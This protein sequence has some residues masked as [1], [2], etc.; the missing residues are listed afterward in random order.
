MQS[1]T[2]TP[3]PFCYRQA[4][5]YPEDFSVCDQGKPASSLSHSI[6]QDQ[7]L[8]L[9]NEIAT[10]AT[11]DIGNG[12]NYDDKKL[13]QPGGGLSHAPFHNLLPGQAWYGDNNI[14]G[15]VDYQME[16]LAGPSQ[17]HFQPTWQNASTAYSGMPY[18]GG[19]ADPQ[20]EPLAFSASPFPYFG[21]HDPYGAI[22][23]DNNALCSNQFAEMNLGQCKPFA[24]GITET[25]ISTSPTNLFH[26]GHMLYTESTPPLTQ[27]SRVNSLCTPNE[28][29]ALTPTSSTASNIYY[30][31]GVAGPSKARARSLS[32]AS[33][34]TITA[35][36]DSCMTPLAL[37]A[38]LPDAE[39]C[40][41]SEVSPT[42]ADA[43][44]PADSRLDSPP[45]ATRGG[46]SRRPLVVPDCE[47][48]ELVLRG[49]KGKASA[50][51][52]RH[53]EVSSQTVNMGR[54]LSLNLSCR[55]T[56][57][58]P[59]LPSQTKSKKQKKHKSVETVSLPSQQA[60]AAT[61][62]PKRR[63]GRPLSTSATARALVKELAI[64]HLDRTQKENGEPP[65]VVA[66]AF[67]PVLPPFPDVSGYVD[68]WCDD[69]KGPSAEDNHQVKQEDDD[70]SRTDLVSTRSNKVAAKKHRELIKERMK[71]VSWLR[72]LRL[73]A[74]VDG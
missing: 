42:S 68:S 34:D 19:F 28:E 13:T 14:N 3:D 57:P 53:D 16:M 73:G 37:V 24:T 41:S 30:Q 5:L 23:V 55:Q 31:Y 65:D 33:A 25:L 49:D 74:I 17:S 50:E 32:A 48:K 61:V 20:L 71:N 12:V 52:R 67:D 47:R 56:S 46:N 59:P 62:P 29:Y 35:S 22:K 51:K 9:H 66:S 70:N 8:P 26:S 58:P 18:H 2:P 36:F 43:K 10:A 7:F 44:D 6:S 69:S 1:S 11:F 64:A 40:L 15:I 39:D 27:H 4:P 45:S 72:L 60:S 21:S 63:P 38:P 54:G